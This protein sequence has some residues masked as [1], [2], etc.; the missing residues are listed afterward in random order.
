M[1]S[2]TPQ[3]SL[4]HSGQKRALDP[5]EL[6]LQKVVNHQQVLGIEPESS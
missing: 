5:L 1:F 3:C 2:C 6:Q 4:Y